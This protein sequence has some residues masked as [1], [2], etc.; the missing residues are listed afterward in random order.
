LS[1]A[2]IRSGFQHAPHFGAVKRAVGL[3]PRSAHSGTSRSVEQ[4]KLNAGTI[5]DATHDAA[6]GIDFAHEVAFADTADRRVTRHLA[7]EVEIERH[8]RRFRTKA[9]RS[10]CGF[11]AGMT[12]ANHH[13]IEDFIK[14]HE[15]LSLTS[16]TSRCKRSR[17]SVPE[18]HPK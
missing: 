14:S 2:E 16:A 4:A 7:D 5:N 1:E 11:A 18:F 17:R 13:D 12:A 10:G 8:E 15:H 9:G 6:E 3:G